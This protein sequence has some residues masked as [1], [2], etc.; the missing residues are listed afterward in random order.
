MT[1]AQRNSKI[2]HGSVAAYYSARYR[3]LSSRGG[4]DVPKRVVVRKL[5][6][7]SLRFFRAENPRL[8]GASFSTLFSTCVITAAS[9]N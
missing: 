3:R 8:T 9:H 1:V 6:Q 5:A 2:Y 4:S 7:K